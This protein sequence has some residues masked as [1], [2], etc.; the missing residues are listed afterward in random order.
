MALEICILATQHNLPRLA[1]LLK[2]DIPR[3]SCRLG[4][5]VTFHAIT[6]CYKQADPDANHL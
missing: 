1:R 4:A 6:D 5:I 2:A 3:Y